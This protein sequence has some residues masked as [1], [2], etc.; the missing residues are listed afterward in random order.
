MNNSINS[1]RQFIGKLSIAA[2]TIYITHQYRVF[3]KGYRS[4]VD[5]MVSG[6][7]GRLATLFYTLGRIKGELQGRY[8]VYKQNRSQPR[9]DT[10]NG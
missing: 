1:I 10:H 2:E 4:Y 6:V 3:F 8:I 9:T 5:D 7:Q